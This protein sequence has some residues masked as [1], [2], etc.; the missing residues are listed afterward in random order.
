MIAEYVK[1]GMLI[2]LAQWLLPKGHFH[3]DDDVW[4][5]C[6]MC[7]HSSHDGENP[8][9]WNEGRTDCDCGYLEKMERFNRVMRECNVAIADRYVIVSK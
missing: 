2:D 5:C 9:Q 6:P 4:Y 8:P 7:D 1:I 3:M